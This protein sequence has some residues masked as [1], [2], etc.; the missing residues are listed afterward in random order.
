M[1]LEVSYDEL[2]EGGTGRLSADGVVALDLSELE[3]SVELPDVA[4]IVS[5]NNE[6][7]YKTNGAVRFVRLQLLASPSSIFLLSSLDYVGNQGQQRPQSHR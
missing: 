2:T 4:M 6:E 3:A 7:I 1:G 5:T